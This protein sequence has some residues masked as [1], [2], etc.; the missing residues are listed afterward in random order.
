MDNSGKAPYMIPEDANVVMHVNAIDLL[1]G[2]AKVGPV[3]TING[4]VPTV[5]AGASAPYR[6]GA[7]PYSGANNFSLGTT[8]VLQFTGAQVWSACLIYLK[9]DTSQDIPFCSCGFNTTGGWIMIDQTAT[10]SA[11]VNFPA[12]VYAETAVAPTANTVLV[13]QIGWD[14]NHI[15]CQL[16][17]T[18]YQSQT[19]ANASAASQNAYIGTGITLAGGGNTYALNGVVYE[20]YA[21]QTAP[22]SALFTSIYNQIIAVM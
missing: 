15:C 3:W 17:N 7:G 10:T 9:N 18:A 19:S 11:G 14:G 20:A 5:P 13:L 8:N 4:T 6:E 21:T 16:N 12:N 1:G 2:T 22:S